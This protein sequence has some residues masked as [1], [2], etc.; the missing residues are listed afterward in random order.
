M[1]MKA[2]NNGVFTHK[3]VNNYSTAF[4]YIKSIQTLWKMEGLSWFKQ[5]QTT[6]LMTVNKPET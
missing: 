3:F 4:N 2:A 5:Q 1:I 6:V